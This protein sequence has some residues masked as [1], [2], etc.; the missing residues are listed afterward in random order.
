MLLQVAR[1]HDVEGGRTLRDGEQRLR[2][3]RP[4]E[5]GER[6][7]QHK[8]PVDFVERDT[9]LAAVLAHTRQLAL[10]VGE[11]DILNVVGELLIGGLQVAAYL[12][13]TPRQ[14]EARVV[15]LQ[16]LEGQLLRVLDRPRKIHV[17]YP[18]HSLYEESIVEAGTIVRDK[19]VHVLA[20]TVLL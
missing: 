7:L 2:E 9:V 8:L 1:L 13:Q 6:P 16:V 11:G 12:R 10:P 18:R 3:R 19:D 20:E 14:E 15:E 4:V 5:V 17:G